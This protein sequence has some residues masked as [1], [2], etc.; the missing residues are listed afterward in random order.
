[1]GQNSLA[2][3]RVGSGA[4]IK[5]RCL[6]K[7]SSTRAIHKS[8]TNIG[9]TISTLPTLAR[10]YFGTNGIRGIPGKD[11]T[12]EFLS[13]I[14]QSIGTYM[15]NS[16]PI[17]VG[18]DVRNSSP[19]LSKT[20][21][22]GLLSAGCDSNSGGLAPTPAHQYAVRTLGYDGGVIVTA[23]HNP[24]QYNG[25]KLVGPD[26]VEVERQS[27]V[28]VEEIYSDKKYS[29]ADWQT[30]GKLGKETRIVEN[31]ISGIMSRVEVPRIS[32]RRFTIV[33]D[34]GNGAQAVSA[35]YLCERLGCKVITINGQADGNF[36]GRGPEPVPAL[37][38]DLSNAVSSYRAHLGVA[39]DGDGDR[40][41]FCD[42]NGTI[43]WGDRTGSMLIDHLLSK[44]PGASVATTVSTS[45]LVGV[46]ASG[47][48]SNV[49]WTTVGSVD[50]S[51][52]MINNSAPLGLEENGGFFY[53]PHIPVRD[54][55]MTTALVLEAL[56]FKGESFSK[57]ISKL[58]TFYQKK[59]K[60]DCPNE[61]KKPVMSILEQESS[62][63]GKIDRTD[64]L[65]IWI[66]NQTWIL[67]RPS[68]TEP[69]IRVYAESD[70][71]DKLES[72]YVKYETIV[73]EAIKSS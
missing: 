57:A 71:E 21:L 4:N 42:E 29:R 39:Y 67:L 45:S 2:K 49:I 18:H 65:K 12:L 30:V 51:R 68:G 9:T 40:S 54:G 7:L 61:K 70:S 73:E 19:A 43:Y 48:G 72:T 35:P 20:V 58:K 64:G 63:E 69:L 14:S 6:P 11:L 50:V 24:A 1:M 26:G 53:G 31:Y 60:F 55:A 5:S 23:S 32:E 16:R 44:H 59:S 36:P 8:Q 33:L 52:A 3:T 66:D 41:L 22:S 46:V 47:H 56:A 17:L 62:K 27:E 10:K 34:I 15:G 13:E 37:L 28:I 38:K 25:V